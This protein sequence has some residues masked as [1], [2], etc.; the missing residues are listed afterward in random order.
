MLDKEAPGSR[1][2]SRSAI[3]V[4]AGRRGVRPIARWLRHR[5]RR[6]S[7]QRFACEADDRDIAE[8]GEHRALDGSHGRGASSWIAVVELTGAAAIAGVIG[9]A[10]WEQVKKRG[11]QLRDFLCA[12]HENDAE[13]LISRGAAAVLASQY[14][15]DRA[16]A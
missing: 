4:Q 5:Q 13:V 6:R 10:A 8:L 2:T 11:S 7:R 14:V 1:F 3:A 12:L 9:N 15:V 16:E